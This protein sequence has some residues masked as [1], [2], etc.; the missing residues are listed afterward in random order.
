MEPK[1]KWLISK[2]KSCSCTMT[3]VW[4]AVAFCKGCA[5]I[6][7]SPL[8]CVHVADK[9][10]LGSHYRIVAE[11]GRER[12][13]LVPLV[14]S[15]MREK[16]TIFG[17]VD[18]LHQ[19]ISFVMENYKP[20]CLLIATSCVAGVIGDDVEMEAEEAEMTYGIPVLCMPFSGFLGGEYSDGYYKTVDM[21]IHRFFKIQEKVKNRVLLLG[22]QMGPEG[23]YAK[24]VRRILSLF[25]LDVK[26][27]FPAYVPF[28]EWKYIPSAEL[29]VLLGRSG[30]SEGLLHTAEM[31]EKEYQIHSLG[32]IYPIGW[33]NTCAWIRK[34]A[35][36]KE[37]PELG[38]KVVSEEEGRLRAYVQTILHVTEGKSA[39]IGI[40]RGPVW[41][42][43]GDTIR[44]VERLHMTLRGVILYDNLSEK[45]KEIYK[46][47]IRK[48][49]DVPILDGKDSQEMMDASDLLL[50]TNEIV[51]T[52]AKQ[53]FIPMVP[54]AGTTGEIVTL[55]T[56][57]RLLCR[58]GNKGGIAYATV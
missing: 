55:R 53:F 28:S 19:C 1:T 11:G 20:K 24:E 36:W 29:M 14:S 48:Y 7:H 8:G 6:F 50:T 57:Y 18:R 2:N 35:E 9:L 5:V 49:T 23:Q 54:L 27:Q 4:R 37:E 26:W 3:G 38:E 56:L 40:G 15:H 42:D 43:P 12:F 33:E 25:G 46:D 31:L 30:E 10:E 32:N 45:E 13:D 17:A 58:Y 47:R 52:K 51:N 39:S 21:I 41:Y 44:S 34:I 16:D 22:D